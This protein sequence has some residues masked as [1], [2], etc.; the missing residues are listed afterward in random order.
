MNMKRTYLHTVR[1]G[2]LLVL[3]LNPHLSTPSITSPGTS[4]ASSP[5]DTTC[6]KKS[7]FIHYGNIP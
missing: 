2:F 7:S 3:L 6:S 5:V 4:I 1:L